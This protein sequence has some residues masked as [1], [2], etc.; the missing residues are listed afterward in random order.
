MRILLTLAVVVLV[1]AL[2]SL[3]F[4]KDKN[5]EHGVI[6]WGEESISIEIADTVSTRKQG[7]SERPTLVGGTGM[8]FIF[9]ESDRHGIWMKDMLFSIDIIWV[10]ESFTI[11][12]IKDNA[13]PKSFPEVFYPKAKAKYALEINALEAS[14]YGTI[15]DT[16][17]FE[18][19]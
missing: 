9:D 17:R 19:R 12:D 18:I 4:I 13:T 14:Q 16:I 3:G 15:R 2:S 7:L 8:F 1:G 10:D 11:I 6:F 5:L